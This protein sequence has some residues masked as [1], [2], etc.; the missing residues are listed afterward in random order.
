MWVININFYISGDFGSFCARFLGNSPAYD[1]NNVEH[2]MRLKKGIPLEKIPEI[3]ITRPQ[4]PNLPLG[5]CF[6]TLFVRISTKTNNQK[7]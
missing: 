6:Q 5:N 2:R 7:I 1:P 4:T 3:E